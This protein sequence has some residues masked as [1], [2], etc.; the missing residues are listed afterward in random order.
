[1]VPIWSRVAKAVGRQGGH[2][3]P[4]AVFS[5]AIT[6]ISTRLRNFPKVMPSTAAYVSVVAIV[7]VRV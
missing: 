1:M 5:I 2:L 3:E 6:L 7:A 4:N